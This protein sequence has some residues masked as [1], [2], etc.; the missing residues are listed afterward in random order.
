MVVFA[1]TCVTTS[2]LKV[3]APEFY[4]GLMHHTSYTWVLWRFL[5]DAA[6]GPWSRIKRTSRDGPLA[7]CMAP[8]YQ[9]AQDPTEALTRTSTNAGQQTATAPCTD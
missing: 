8:V 7:P 6:M 2:Q 3:I 1:D 5:T 4:L 9:D